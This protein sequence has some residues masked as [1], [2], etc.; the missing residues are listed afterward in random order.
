MP[1]FWCLRALFSCLWWELGRNVDN[2]ADGSESEVRDEAS[3]R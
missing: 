1:V 3:R 2:D